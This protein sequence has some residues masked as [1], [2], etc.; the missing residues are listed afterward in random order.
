MFTSSIIEPTQ[1]SETAAQH[2]VVIIGGGI[3]GLSAAWYL[4]QAGVPYTVLEAAQRW[5][6][7]IRTEHV[8]DF[9]VEAG[10]DSFLVQKPW[11]IQL[12]REL[13]L[14]D[15]LIPINQPKHATYVL[16]RGKLLPLP[17]GVSLI[18]PTK[19]LPFA[20]SPLI[21]PLGKL[22]M[23]LDL[24]IPAKRD[25]R[26]ETLAAFVRRRLGAEALDKIA[27]PLMSGIFNA[28]S[29]KQS[30][31]ATFPRFRQIER[32]H[33]SLIRGMVAARRQRSA[34]PASPASP[35]FMTLRDGVETLVTTLVGKLTGD[36]RLKNAVTSIEKT[37]SGYR[38][39][40]N[41]GA[42]IEA[43]S[44]ILTL[45]ANLSAAL[46][47]PLNAAVAD[48]LATIRYVSSGTISLAF[49]ANAITNQL[50]GFGVVIPKSEHRPINAITISS[51][52]FAY[53]VP[54]DQ[55]LVRVFFGGSRSP[56]SMN[57]S[58][59]DLLTMVRA[60]LRGILGIYA[61]PLLSK[62]YRWHNANPQ[63]DL[64]HLERIGSIER[65]L[66]AGLYLT[67]SSYRGV[68]MPDCV[69]Q[70]QQ[71]TAQVINDLQEVTA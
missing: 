33:G 3:S 39:Q 32:D 43:D 42:I 60:Q 21:S 12:A 6:G 40:A 53:R 50:D 2:H 9:V 58:D 15:Q 36:L 62:I 5:G 71:V 37:S 25:D 31:M 56:Q 14:G 69:H 23:A 55:V 65:A 8:N 35:A 51:R 47:R 54:N 45:S 67:G 16:Q 4:Q 70:A 68:G 26:D 27:E 19:F 22:R 29:A 28:E 7:K 44:V 46:L 63:Y 34:T 61:E 13:G 52:K 59:D 48:Q 17:E 10:P 38:I 64:N 24:V 66:P 41:D 1:S 11:A 57:L 18:V 49:P 20:M 30:I